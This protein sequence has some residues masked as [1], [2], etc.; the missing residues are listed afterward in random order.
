M[1]INRKF[2]QKQIQNQYKQNQEKIKKT[3]DFNDKWEVKIDTV[4]NCSK[5]PEKVDVFINQLVKCKI[6]AL[7]KEYKDL[8]W[9]A[10]LIGENMVVEDIYVPNQKITSTTIDKVNCPEFNTL[11][12]I[13]VIHSHNNMGTDFSNTD[14]DWINQNHNISICI[15]D[16]NID[17]QVRWKTPC[18]SLKIVKANIKSKIDID[19]NSEKFIKIIKEKIMKNTYNYNYGYGHGY[20]YKNVFNDDDDFLTKKFQEDIEKE[21]DEVINDFDDKEKTLVEEL[22]KLEEM[23]DK[24][25]K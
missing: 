4:K 21:I 6:D 18:G 1:F 22:S 11:S 5:A 3:F 19:F 10:Y 15:S 23:D 17:G 13:G 24:E 16:S 12:V 14:K 25:K 2:K 9:L 7:M 20:N 8:E